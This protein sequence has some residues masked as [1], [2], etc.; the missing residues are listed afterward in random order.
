[1][2][3]MLDQAVITELGTLLR[4]SL[5]SCEESLLTHKVIADLEVA[6]ESGSCFTIAKR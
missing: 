5:R 6:S 3:E 2:Y 1:M 4:E